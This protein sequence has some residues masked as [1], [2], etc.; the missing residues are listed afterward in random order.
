VPVQVKAHGLALPYDIA[1]GESE[2]SADLQAQEQDQTADHACRDRRGLKQREKGDV[3]VV[4]IPPPLVSMLLEHVDVYGLADDGRLFQSEYG[5]VVAASSYS[6]IWKRARELALP[7]GQV[8][9]VMAARPYD[10]RHAG[11]SQWLNSGVPAPEVAA[12]AGHSVDVLL[13]IYAKCIDGQEAEMNDRI[14]RG[15]GDEAGG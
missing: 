7:P 8:T 15:L 1:G 5:N 4:P 14:M 12:R 11:V 2:D 9:S 6:R 13:R 3:R 10:L